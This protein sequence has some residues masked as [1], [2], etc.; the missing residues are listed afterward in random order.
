MRHRLRQQ[1]LLY[2]GWWEAEPVDGRGKGEGMY[3][4]LLAYESSFVLMLKRQLFIS[5]YVYLRAGPKLSSFSR[6]Y[7]GGRGPKA[8]RLFRNVVYDALRF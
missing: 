8:T 5:K 4:K 1:T 6:A 2:V 3:C 7:T